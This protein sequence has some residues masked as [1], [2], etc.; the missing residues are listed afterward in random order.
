MR[1]SPTLLLP[2]LLLLGCVTT[3]TYDAKVAELA[4]HDQDA[5]GR[6]EALQAKVTALEAKVRELDTQRAAAVAERDALRTSLDDNTALV[7]ELKKRLEKLGQNVD[8]LS[9]ERGQLAGA[10]DEAK[11]RLEELRKQKA[12]AEA[13]AA[14]FRS[15]VQQLHS[16]IDAG[17]MK[18]VI[19]DGRMLIAL[20]N[21]V[22][23]DSGST[24][25]KKDAQAALAQVATVLA[26]IPDRRFLVAGH[27][28][29]VPIHTERFPSNWELSASRALEVTHFLI[30]HGMRAQ[31][32]AAGGYG[33]FDPVASNDAPDTRGLNRRIEI[34][35]QPNLGELPSLEGLLAPA[36]K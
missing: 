3:S 29:N 17:K 33:E 6:E 4:R 19:R 11:G 31:V 18:V 10:L 16:M 21:D 30:A 20:P 13:L 15:L 28:D 23:F 36:S 27:T 22:L 8:K 9:S 2:G 12:A 32:L 34:V 35:L 5:R 7:S 1:L 14:T 24:A 26:G 25:L